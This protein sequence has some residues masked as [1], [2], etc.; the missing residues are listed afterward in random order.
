MS[1]IGMSPQS[2]EQRRLF[3][4][5][6]V[7]IVNM[8]AEQGLALRVLG[9]LAFHIHCQRYVA[10]QKQL[11]RAYTDIDFAGYRKQASKIGPFLSK[12]G[13]RED[14]DINVLYA[15]ER[16]IYNHP[17]S[18]LHIDIFFDKLNFCHEINW[19]GRLEV[20]QP[21]LPLAEMLLEKMQIVKINEKDIIDT[22]MLLLEH[23]LGD[24][25]RETINIARISGLCAKDWGLWRTITMN[26]RKVADLGQGYEQLSAVE[27]SRLGSQVESALA[28]INE[29]PKTTAWKLRA[30]IGDRVKW[31]QDVDDIS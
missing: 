9:S 16:L 4:D 29:E 20:D 21:T 26:L 6:A 8:A 25:D 28:R 30:K 17:S 3:E 23:S 18:G 27:K 12:L 31:Y 22:L 19:V 11:G 7:R 2:D 14:L 1:Q 5:E 24:D 13:Y 10:L 15:G